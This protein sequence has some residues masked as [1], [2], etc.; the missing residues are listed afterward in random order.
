M[1]EGTPFGSP[2]VERKD[3]RGAHKPKHAFSDEKKK[4][5]DDHIMS[6]NPCVSHYRRSHAPNRLYLPAEITIRKM[7]ESYNEEKT[8]SER[9]SYTAYERAVKAK[10]ITDSQIAA[11]KNAKLVHFSNY[12]GTLKMTLEKTVTTVSLSSYTNGSTL[13]PEFV[14]MQIESGKSRRG[15]CML[16]LT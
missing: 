3:R 12:T 8:D 4:D 7:L 13:K 5:I 9:I 15:L 6:F 14:M 16:P 1:F 2:H 10:N 11:M